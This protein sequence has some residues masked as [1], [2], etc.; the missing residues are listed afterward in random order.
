MR[1]KSLKKAAALALTGAFLCAVFPVSTWAEEPVGNAE[2]D[3]LE[4]SFVNAYAQAGEE[5]E[6][7]VTGGADCTYKWYVGGRLQENTKNSYIPQES[8]LENMIRVEVSSGGST[9]EAEMYFSNLPVVYIDTEGGVPVTS[10]DNYIDGEM[11]MQ[12]NVDYDPEETTLYSGKLEIKGRGNSTWGMPKKPYKLKLDKSTNIMDMGKNKHWVLLAN[13][14]DPSLMR[15]TVVYDLSGELGMPHM[16]T[17]WVD[18]VMNGTYVGNYQ[19]CEQIR[20]SGGRVDIFDWETLAEDAAS[21]IA[22]AEGM[23]DS[24]DLED[25]MAEDLSWV[26]SGT[27]SYDGKEYQ[28]E[29]YIDIPDITGG[30]LLELDEY[31]D[32]L[33]KFR[34]DSGQPIMVNT[35]EFA[36]TN[37]DMMDYLAGYIQAFEDAV[38]A[39]D[40]SA[41]YKGEQLHYSELFDFD[42]LVDYWLLNEIFYNEEINK[43]STYMYQDLDGL[44]KMGPLWD[45]DYSS[46]GEGDTGKTNG[47]AT[48][49]FSRN[50]QANMWYKDLIHDPYFVLKAQERYWEIRGSLIEDVIR[51]GGTIDSSRQLLKWSGAA[52]ESLWPYKGGFTAGVNTFKTWMNTHIDWLDT[53]FKTEESVLASLSGYTSAGNLVFSLENDLGEAL[54]NDNISENA[55]ASVLTEDGRDVTLKVQTTASGAQKARLYVN[56]ISADILDLTAGKAEYVI[57]AESLTASAGE[58]DVIEAKILGLDGQVITKGYVTIRETEKTDRVTGIEIQKPDKSEYLAGEELDLTGF[59]V[60][61]VRESGARENVTADASVSGFTGEAGDNTITV[62]YGEYSDTFIVKVKALTGIRIAAEPDKT[63]YIQGEAFSPEG[64]SV[65]AVYSDGSEEEITDYEI[66]GY[67]GEQAGSQELTVNYKGFSATVTVTVDKKEDDPSED[68]PAVD[69]PSED[70]PSVDKPSEDT[71]SGDPSTG[72]SSQDRPDDKQNISDGGKDN[73]DVRTEGADSIKTGDTTLPSLW[74]ISAVLAA[75]AVLTLGY[76]K[77]KR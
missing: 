15:N 47:W 55:S 56:G 77:K 50:A 4:V 8:D 70:D 23:D 59:A 10:K 71:P 31:Y 66:S 29:D 63:E 39:E 20:V 40:Y 67:D 44:M 28:V 42:S 34:T 62:T 18:V 64:M 51:D 9:A 49:D 45:M 19:F 13:Y 37:T 36:Y 21:E 30:F 72:D 58:K 27:V 24:G 53:Q 35:P 2:T 17:V 65:L 68:D 61:A 54:E 46:G 73:A 7:K 26:T 16:E 32:E 33:S 11:R 14:S 60:Y 52:N 25:M 22:D 69:Q 12:G 57:P 38:Q 1:G 76:R 6:T 3:R 43:K 5:L 48:K 74:I 41:E 75:G